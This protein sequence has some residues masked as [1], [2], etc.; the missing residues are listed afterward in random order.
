MLERCLRACIIITSYTCVCMSTCRRALPYCIIITSCVYVCLH[1]GDPPN[2]LCHPETVQVEL[3][4]D[5]VGFG[6]SLRGWY[7]C[8]HH[9]SQYTLQCVL[10]TVNYHPSATA[11]STRTFHPPHQS[12]CQCNLQ[13]VMYVRMYVF[14]VNLPKLLILYIFK[15]KL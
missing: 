12:Q 2:F 1:V 5:D 15:N 7:R 9:C 14:P 4:S 10:S 3:T 11:L 6:F 13:L 8:D